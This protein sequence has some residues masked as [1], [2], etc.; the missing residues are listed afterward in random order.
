M[1]AVITNVVLASVALMVV[2]AET[3]AMLE[4]VAYARRIDGSLARKFRVG[5][6]RYEWASVI[7][8][9]TSV[10]MPAYSIT[11]PLALFVATVFGAVTGM[12]FAGLPGNGPLT[13]FMGL[14]VSGGYFVKAYGASFVAHREHVAECQR[15]GTWH[16][17]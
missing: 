17:A 12:E 7:W 6:V 14:A 9:E 8:H 13:I 5:S 16:L 15:Q 10:E 3:Y 2:Q 4:A 1:Y 11:R